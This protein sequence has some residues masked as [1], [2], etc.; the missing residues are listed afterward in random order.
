MTQPSTQSLNRR[1]T[2]LAI[3]VLVL[4]LGLVALG[5]GFATSIAAVG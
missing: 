2:I 5:V 3:L 4:L 1:L